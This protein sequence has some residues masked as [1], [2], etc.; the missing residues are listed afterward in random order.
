MKAEEK[1]IELPDGWKWVKLGDVFYT[2]SGGTPSRKESKYYQG[3]IPWVKSG[4]LNKGLITDTE[5]KISEE[6]IKNSSAKV[7]LKGTLLIALYGATIGKLAMLG[8]DAATN[9]A[10]CGI[11]ESELASS[12]YL[13]HYLFYKKRKLVSQGIGGAQPNISQTILKDLDFPLP[14]IPIQQA[15]VSKIEELFSELDK[16]IESLITARQQLRTYRQCLF[17]TMFSGTIN[18]LVKLTDVCDF[19]TK[20]T[21][22]SKD[23]MYVVQGDIPFLKVYNLTFSGLIDF[24]I[25]PTFVNKATNNGLLKRSIVLPGDVLMNIVG[26]PL[27]KVSLVPNSYQEW[28]INQAIVRFRCKTSLYNKFLMYFLLFDNTIKE[29]SKKAKAT[30]GQFNLTLEICREIELNLPPISD[31]VKLVQELESRLSV[32]DKMKESITQGLQKAATLRQSILKK[33]F[34]GKLSEL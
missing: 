7:F 30:A 16:G 24:T 21:T 10:I 27:G 25:N 29:Y 20:G 3:N 14:P 28:N 17:K 13:Y 31:Q 23:E 11:C 32:A 9:Q 4:E 12:K 8:I 19:I 5:E 26:P 15:I 1:K 2:T 6:A 34:E 18:N 22:P 33:A